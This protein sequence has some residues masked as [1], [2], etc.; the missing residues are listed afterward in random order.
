MQH[1]LNLSQQQAEDPRV[2]GLLTEK[3]QLDREIR[4]LRKKADDEVSAQI[5]RFA[6]QNGFTSAELQIHPPLFWLVRVVLRS[7]QFKEQVM[8][9]FKPTKDE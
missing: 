6:E 7:R 8:S 3:V 4:E 5:V 1:N 2:F 9:T